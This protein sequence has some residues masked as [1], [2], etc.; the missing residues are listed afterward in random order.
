[1]KKVFPA[2]AAA[3]ILAACSSN[4][5][6][7]NIY[8]TCTIPELEGACIFLV[9]ELEKVIEPTKENLDSTFI[10][11]GKFEFHG[12][13]ERMSDLRIERYKRIGVQNLLV[14]TEPGDI[15]VTIGPESSGYGTPQNDSLQV[16]KDLT[17]KYW[18]QYREIA[19]EGSVERRDS[20]T[21]AYYERMRQM[22]SG[23]DP[24][25]QLTAFFHKRF[26]KTR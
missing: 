18:T 22:V 16:W 7:F 5:K 2:M 10:V 4:D 11:D 15:F 21:S 6:Q 19:S 1:M 8:G 3:L 13:V 26:P 12:K 20:L 17:E 24:D 25:S 9:P 14:V 23:L